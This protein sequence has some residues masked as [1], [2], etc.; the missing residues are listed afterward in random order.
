MFGGVKILRNSFP[1]RVANDLKEICV[2]LAPVTNRGGDE[3]FPCGRE[4]EE[5]DALVFGR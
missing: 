4:R 2:C 1:S 3:L 5:F